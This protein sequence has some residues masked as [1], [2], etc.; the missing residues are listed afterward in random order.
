[1]LT[2]LSGVGREK[3]AASALFRELG[4]FSAGEPVNMMYSNCTALPLKV[5]QSLLADFVFG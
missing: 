1:M 4:L 3:H 5:A 2:I